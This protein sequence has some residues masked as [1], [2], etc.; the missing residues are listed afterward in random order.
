MEAKR[1]MLVL[2]KAA[3]LAAKQHGMDN[4]LGTMEKWTRARGAL[5]GLEWGEGFRQYSGHAYPRTP[6]L[7]ELLAG[8]VHLLAK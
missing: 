5:V 4:F 3:R 2:T 8:D 6:L 1:A 7:Q